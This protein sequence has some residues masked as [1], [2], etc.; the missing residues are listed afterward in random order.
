MNEWEF[1][2]CVVFHFIIT[3]LIDFNAKEYK[4]LYVFI[5]LYTMLKE[6]ETWIIIIF[7]IFFSIRW[8]FFMHFFVKCE[9]NSLLLVHS[10]IVD[11]L[12]STY[13]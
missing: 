8:F 5:N 12:Q 4:M 1:C 2:T 6:H 10:E 9:Q 11:Q 13:V 3:Y 7:I